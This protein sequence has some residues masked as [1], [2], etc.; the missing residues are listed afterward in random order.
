METTLCNSVLVHAWQTVNVSPR[1]V[2]ENVR[3][4]LISEAARLL[5]DDGAAALTARRLAALV[6]TSTTAV[7]TYFGSMEEL[8]RA[9][10]VEGFTRLADWLGRVPTSEDPV[11]DVAALGAAYVGNARANPNLYRAMFLDNTFSDAE[12]DLCFG[13]FD[14]LADAMERCV[15]AGVVNRED[16][17]EL[18]QEFWAATHGV[19]SL[20]LAQ[21]WSDEEAFA[22]FAGLGRVLFKGLGVAEEHIAAAVGY[23]A[24]YLFAPQPHV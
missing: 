21:M 14:R 13:T 4:A 8:R 5:H 19:V 24:R 16:G 7:Y 6:G 12:R 18:A 17:W 9:V 20:L 15:R 22:R 11:A 10:R 23:S 2:D 3:D 1:A